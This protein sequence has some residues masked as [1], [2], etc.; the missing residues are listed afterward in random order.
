[1]AR[2]IKELTCRDRVRFVKDALSP[3]QLR[4]IKKAVLEQ[5]AG[6]DKAGVGNSEL[7][8][9]R[10]WYEQQTAFELQRP[11]PLPNW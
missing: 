8:N 10:V 2:D 5:A 6:E 3:E 4:I 9:T 11:A 7:P 1:M